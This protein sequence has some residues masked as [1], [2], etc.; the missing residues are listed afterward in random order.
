MLVSNLLSEIGFTREE[1]EQYSNYKKI[2]GN[3][4]S[5]PAK[6]YMLGK[7]GFEDAV[8]L[9][10]EIA[11]DGVHKYTVHLLFLLECTSYLLDNYIAKGIDKSI[12]VNSMKDIKYKLDE[13]IKVKN[14]FGIFVLNWYRGFFEMTRFALGRLQ[15]DIMV[16][17][18]E[19]LEISGYKIKDGDFKLN[20]HIPSAGPLTSEKVNES[21]RIAY[22]FFKDRLGG[23]ILPIRCSSWLL[24]PPYIKV[25]GE[26]SNTTGF[27]RNFE[28]YFVKKT[29]NFSDAWR[30]FAVDFDGD[31]KKLPSETSMQRSFID[32]IKNGGTF[33]TAKG[34]ILFD[35]ENVLTRK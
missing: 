27:V 29:D 32:Y 13:C 30:V 31:I 20:C 5:E 2:I 7:T 23:R 12:F 15:Y 25:F 8:S 19:E 3:A 10:D 18:G 9:L 14:V 21:L 34:I 6:C 24:Y 17:R 33:G 16:H 26:N 4:V 1:Q 22:D 11:I 28:V 35:G